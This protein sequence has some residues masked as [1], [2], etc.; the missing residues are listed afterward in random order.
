[1]SKLPQTFPS[2]LATGC[3]VILAATIIALMLTGTSILER[4]SADNPDPTPAT[5][6]VT[7]LCVPDLDCGWHPPTCSSN[8]HK[9]RTYHWVWGGNDYGW[10]TCYR[11][12]HY[13]CVRR[14]NLP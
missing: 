13:T 4:A 12:T 11:T 2:L 8:S 3:K 6:L 10:W 14:L 5:R 7:P 1:M 9:G